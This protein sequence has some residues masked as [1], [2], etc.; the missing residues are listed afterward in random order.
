MGSEH[1]AA[2]DELV[3]DVDANRNAGLEA[4]ADEAGEEGEEK[5]A[6]P[7]VAADDDGTDVITV[8]ET[9]LS[10]G[11][12]ERARASSSA[13]SEADPGPDPHGYKRYNNEVCFAL[14]GNAAGTRARGPAARFARPFS[15]THAR[16]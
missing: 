14:R 9:S 12:L 11:D 3:R 1:V 2:G 10:T 16:Y 8:R 13:W 15:P 7:A 4:R 5:E 6:E